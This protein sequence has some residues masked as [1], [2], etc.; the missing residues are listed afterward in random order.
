MVYAQLAG[1]HSLR[2]LEGSLSSHG[3]LLYHLGVERVRRATLSDANRD[4][5]AAIYEEVF[6]LLL[7]RVNSRLGRAMGEALRLLDATSIRLN[8][9]LFNW[10]RFS[11]TWTTAKLHVVYDPQAQVPTYFA[12]TPGRVNDIVEAKKM[13]IEAGATYVFDKGYY[14]FGFWARLNG[15]GCRFV[16]RLKENSPVTVIESFALSDEAIR[17][18]R[19][20]R[21]NDRM[22]SSR[23]NPYQ[24]TLREV[25]V[26]LEDG[27]CLRLVSNDLDS[28]A[29]EIAQLYKARWQIELFFKWVKQNLKIKKFLGTSQNA[30]KIQIVTALIAYL[31]LRLAHITWPSTLSMQSLAR[32]IKTNLMH[33]KTIPHLLRPPKSQKRPPG[34]QLIM[35]LQHVPA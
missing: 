29:S 18:D 1:S 33:R 24:G 20:V 23:K 14:D 13:P 12:I 27:R 22:A 15:A 19:L 2:D 16:T 28:P 8:E 17:S 21:L 5:P 34:P 11:D 6:A 4:R 9:T 10:A 7:G 3:N 26:G 25:M 35:D 32:L 31:L 30:V